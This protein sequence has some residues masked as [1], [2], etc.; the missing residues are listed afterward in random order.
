MPMQRPTK[1]MLEAVEN[2][3]I[4]LIKCGTPKCWDIPNNLEHGCWANIFT[5]GEKCRK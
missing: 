3:I 5:R 4:N 1:E 2:C